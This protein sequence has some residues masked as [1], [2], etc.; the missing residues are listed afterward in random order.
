M[1]WKLLVVVLGPTLVAAVLAATSAL[2]SW[3]AVGTYDRAAELV[4]LDGKIND[5][6]DAL[7]QE[8]DITAG[9][10]SS[11]RT[12]GNERMLAARQQV[13]QAASTY[14]ATVAEIDTDEPA[15]LHE[16]VLRADDELNGL[17]F[18]RDAVTAASL[19]EGAI[20]SG[21]TDTIAKLFDV[22]NYD[23][24]GSDSQ[25]SHGLRV[26]G[27]F[28]LLKEYTSQ[29]RAELAGITATGTFA[30]GQL[31]DLTGTIARQ[32]AAIDAF[33]SDSSDAQRTAYA[34]TLQGGAVSQVQTIQDAVIEQAT[35]EKVTVEAGPAFDAASQK[36]ALLRTVQGQ[37]L[38]GVIADADGFSDAALLSAWLAIGALALVV[39][40]AVIMSIVVA[41]SMSRSLRRLRSSA[42]H[43]A[44]DWL[45]D[46]TERLR[47]TNVESVS[48]VQVAR[49]GNDADD[50]IGEVAR[51]FDAI[52]AACAQLAREQAELRVSMNSGFIN[53][54]RRNQQCVAR[55]LHALD[56]WERDELD[57][58]RLQRL[59]T[60]DH[61]ATRMKRNDD[62]LMIIAGAQTVTKRSRPSSLDDVMGAALS[63]V[64]H[65]T[66]VT[67]KSAGD[68]V[69][70]GHAVLDIVH[71][72]AELL[73]N[74]TAFSP[75]NRAVNTSYTKSAT[76]PG[77]IVVTIRD[78]GVGMPPERLEQ[79]N[80]R[81]ASPEAIDG[82]MVRSMGLIVVGRLAARHGINV[83]LQPT[84]GGG[85]TAT[86]VLPANILLG[87][88]ADNGPLHHSAVT[89]PPRS[90]PQYAEV[91]TELAPHYPAADPESTRDF[92][93]P[94]AASAAY[95]LDQAVA[96]RRH[97]RKL[98]GAT[99]T[100]GS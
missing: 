10:V 62:S 9:F 63:E 73:D 27:D 31:Q 97:R 66:R 8:R 15:I 81:I 48:D 19:T 90:T 77:C 30:V 94:Q 67:R 49:M 36:L 83:L 78:R 5:L 55:I 4:R 71:L 84:H 79:N 96:M 70:V 50:E 86:V 82:S 32:Q 26:V 60:L 22:V 3:G 87:V 39:L 74:A 57:A 53:L 92:D 37:V 98:G 40:L 34:N 80:R 76:T 69:V 52:A 35:A 24:A 11:G 88:P 85:I 65:Y 44:D 99:D 14:R 2:S 23:P 100:K 33:Q 41:R 54:A 47:L 46:I 95:S 13:D 12:T 38:D 68:V 16:A 56:E 25:M 18:V 75:P 7:Q 61:L 93:L 29:V 59:F 58:D 21:Y 91:L 28:F 64:E 42:L 89:A 6:V 17:S 51:A 72:L 20:R 43:V 1:R 45:P